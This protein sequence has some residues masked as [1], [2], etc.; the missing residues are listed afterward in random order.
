MTA[1]FDLRKLSDVDDNAIFNDHIVIG[2]SEFTTVEFTW[3]GESS[4]DFTPDNRPHSR[5]FKPE[6]AMSPPS[7]I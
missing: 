4:I 3:R 2:L 5:N 1:S 7:A 6:P